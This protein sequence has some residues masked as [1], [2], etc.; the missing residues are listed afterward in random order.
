MKMKWALVGNGVWA[1]KIHAPGLSEY[2]GIDFI[3]IWGRDKGRSAVLS[4]RFGVKSFDSFEELLESADGISFAIAPVGQDMLAPLAIAKGKHV[5][6]EKPVSTEVN[7]IRNLINRCEPNQRVGI[8]L[9]RL[10][11]PDRAAWLR[12]ALGGHFHY[13]E[14]NWLSPAMLDGSEYASSSWRKGAGIIWDIMPHIL[15]Q[16]VPVLGEVTHTDVQPWAEKDGLIIQMAHSN[17]GHSE[18]HTTLCAAPS[19]KSE[20][21]RFYGNGHSTLS[22]AQGVNSKMAYRALLEAIVHGTPFTDDTLLKY[23]TLDA[24]VSTTRIMSDLAARV[25]KIALSK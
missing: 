7:N 19:E 15:S 4:E 9:T 1:K 18:V 20:W 5:L 16:L 22:P 6:L 8:F 25:E 17:G 11:D 21:I 24:A 3:G 2:E 10:F 12:D 13:A 23:A 14:V